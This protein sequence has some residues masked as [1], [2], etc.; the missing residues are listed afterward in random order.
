LPVTVGAGPHGV[1]VLV[2]GFAGRLEVV[3]QQ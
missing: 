3:T 2:A 1:L